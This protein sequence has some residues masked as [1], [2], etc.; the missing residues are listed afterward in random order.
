[1]PLL[2]DLLMRASILLLFVL[3]LMVSN[4][5]SIHQIQG[6]W[7]FGKDAFQSKFGAS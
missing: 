5:I 7:K 4:F 1:V 3:I 2:P 6:A